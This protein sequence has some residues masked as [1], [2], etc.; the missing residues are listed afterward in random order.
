MQR[1]DAQLVRAVRDGDPAGFPAIYGRYR[2]E[3]VRHAT[4]LLG[5]CRCNAEDVVQEAFMRAHRVLSSG[6]A[7][8][9][10]RPWLYRIVRNAAID[11]CRRNSARRALTDQLCVALRPDDTAD[12]VALNWAA[13]EVLTDI[14]G[15]PE[16]QRTAVV[17]HVLHGA[18]HA[19]LARELDISVNASKGLL[20]R[21]RSGLAQAA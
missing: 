21:A 18:P 3:L 11:E 4:R 12:A 13:R 1:S 15:L 20:C 16:R 17:R 2:A 8:I 7:Q 5:D 19:Q 6:D 14:A 10:L 9:V